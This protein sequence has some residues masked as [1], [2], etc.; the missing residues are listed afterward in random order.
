MYKNRSMFNYLENKLSQISDHAYFISYR[1]LFTRI[2][3]SPY[4]YFND[5]QFTTIKHGNNIYMFESDTLLSIDQEENMND[6]E[7][8]F[9]YYGHKFEDYVTKARNNNNNAN[10][11]L[12]SFIYTEESFIGV[13]RQKLNNFNL[14][15][16]GEVDALHKNKLV[17]LKTAFKPYNDKKLHSFYRFKLYKTYIQAILLATNEIKIGYRDEHGIVD[18]IDHF[19]T[20]YN[21]DD[22]TSIPYLIDSYKKQLKLDNEYRQANNVGNFAV[23]Q[24]FLYKL[25]EWITYLYQYMEYKLQQTNIHQDY[26]FF[27]IKKLKVMK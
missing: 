16:F 11:S 1:G 26:I 13:C 12:S 15:L 27:F 18:E 17:E 25:L 21:N 2:M 23:S 10:N 14:M 19:T 22:D 8:K 9:C 20:T 4:D 5:W 3:M 7:L 24:N 6:D